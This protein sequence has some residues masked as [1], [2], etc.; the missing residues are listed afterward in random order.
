MKT[1]RVKPRKS[2]FAG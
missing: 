2:T 1:E